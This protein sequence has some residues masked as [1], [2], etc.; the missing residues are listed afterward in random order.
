LIEILY[1]DLNPASIVNLTMSGARGRLNARVDTVVTFP[2]FKKTQRVYSCQSYAPMSKTQH[3]KESVIVERHLSTHYELQK[4]LPAYE[5]DKDDQSE[6]DDSEMIDQWKRPYE[7]GFFIQ[8]GQKG[9]NPIDTDAL[10]RLTP[11]SRLK[12]TTNPHT[13]MGTSSKVNDVCVCWKKEMK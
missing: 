5:L 1:L 13:T 7:R 2:N 8:I 9:Q 12:T 4:S 6:S 10:L 3:P 11:K